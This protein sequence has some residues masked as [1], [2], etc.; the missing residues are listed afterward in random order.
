[1]SASRSRSRARGA[2]RDSSSRPTPARR[3]TARCSSAYRSAAARSATRSSSSNSSGSGSTTRRRRACSPI[4]R[5]RGGDTG[6][7]RFARPHVLSEPEE[8]LLE[9]TANTGGRAFSRL[10]D[11]I[12]GSLRFPLRRDGHDALLGEEE[13]LALLYDPDREVRR[14]AADSLTRVL[15]QNART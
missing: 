13:V 10:F 1:S 8:R 3:A 11:E 9:E 15:R 7:R 4:R 5:S 2:S 6:S 12:L 14:A